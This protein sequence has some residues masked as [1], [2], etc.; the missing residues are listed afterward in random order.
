MG[1][2]TLQFVTTKSLLSR[3][4]RVFERGWMAHVDSVMADGRLLGTR[5]HGVK[6]RPPHYEKFARVQRVVLAVTDHQEYDYY[7]FLQEQLGKPYE[8]LAIAAFAFDRD[9]RTLG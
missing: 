2:I 3:A 4:I 7:E 1:A 6:I 9:W 8:N 5:E